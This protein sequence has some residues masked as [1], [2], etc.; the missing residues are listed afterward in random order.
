MTHDERLALINRPFWIRNLSPS[1]PWSGTIVGDRFPRGRSGEELLYDDD[2]I[3]RLTV[4]SALDAPITWHTD[5]DTAVA[6]QG[7]E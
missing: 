6:A 4:V 7:D 1:Y 3:T 5:D 2:A